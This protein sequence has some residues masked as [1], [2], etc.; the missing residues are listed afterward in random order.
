MNNKI[1]PKDFG[2]I[3]NLVNV[4][5]NAYCQKEVANEIMRLEFISNALGVAPNIR[6]VLSEIASYSKEASKYKP[7]QKEHWVWEVKSALYR[8]ELYAEQVV[9]NE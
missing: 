3:K 4:I 8:L 1:S 7:N 6:N 9:D 5:I 2:E